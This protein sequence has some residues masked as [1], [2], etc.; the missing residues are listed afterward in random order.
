MTLFIQGPSAELALIDEFY[1][2]CIASETHQFDS[3]ITE[4][5]VEDGSVISDN[6]RNKP[7]VVTMECI[8]SN[9]P[10]DL[11]EKFR[12]GGDARF[13]PSGIDASPADDAYAML[14]AIRKDRR[15]V[16]IETS[17]G[18]YINMGLESLS[19]PRNGNRADE[20]RFTATFRQVE[21]VQ[22]RR[23]TRVAIPIA[24]AKKAK[25]MT[26]KEFKVFATKLGE[27]ALLKA[28]G[29]P[30]IQTVLQN[31][32]KVNTQYF[33]LGGKVPHDSFGPAKGVP[34]QQQEPN[35]ILPALGT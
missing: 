30:L 35:V 9:T 21:I 16:V 20:I 15:L 22:N 18:G 7:V 5:P 28:R 3:E 13:R 33:N 23:G 10:F 12:R 25:S 6:I 24:I 14:L 27:T 26:P 1:I 32:A 19:I 2:D 29:N 4:F 8:V 11:I 17:L 31:I 34:A